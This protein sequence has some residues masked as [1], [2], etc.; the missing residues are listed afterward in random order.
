MRRSASNNLMVL[1]F[2]PPRPNGYERQHPWCMM[3]E[4]RPAVA[5]L[6]GQRQRLAQT[7]ETG[8]EDI[9][10]AAGKQR[11]IRAGDGT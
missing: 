7:M 3:A 1:R 10:G 8:L 6:S 5:G 2:V 4:A 9:N 11:P